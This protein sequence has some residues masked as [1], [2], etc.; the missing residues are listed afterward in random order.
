MTSLSGSFQLPNQLT[1]GDRFTA[2][3]SVLNRSDKTRTIDVTLKA[4]GPIEGGS[5]QI[6]QAVTLG[7][8]KRETVWLPV[9]TVG[10][11]SIKLSA[12]A[13]DRLDKDALAQALPVHKR[14]SLDVAASY[15][16]TVAPGIDETLQFPVDMMPNV[17]EFSVTLASSVLG[18]VDG[19]MRY[20]RDYPYL[21]WEQRLTKA[22]TE[23]IGMS[24]A[25][26]PRVPQRRTTRGRYSEGRI[27]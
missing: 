2:G 7:P 14:V 21:C 25:S 27:A 19:A 22:V 16:T 13:S 18:N 10:D 1:A 24:M 4:V 17:G 26:S 6:H 11:G 15:G 3:F 5:A 8:F 23:P 9:T 12:L 20:V